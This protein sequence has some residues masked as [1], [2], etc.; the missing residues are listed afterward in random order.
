MIVAKTVDEAVAAIAAGEAML[1]AG[2]TSHA[3]RRERTG[4]PFA[5][6]LVSIMRVP[7]LQVLEIGKD[8]ALTMGAAVRQEQLY[9]NTKLRRDW[10]AIDDALEAVGHARIRQMLTVG[11]SV[12]PL[13]GGFDLPLALLTLGA[14]VTVAGPNGRRTVPLAEAFEKRFAKDEMV[15][16]VAVPPQPMR[17]GSSFFKYMARGVLEIPT[18]N[19]AATVTLDGQGK[20]ERAQVAV[21]A[22]SW[23]PIVLDLAALK[24]KALDDAAVRAAVMPVRAAAQPMSDVRGSAAYKRNMAVEFS[25]RAVLQAAAR[26]AGGKA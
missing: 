2:G 23:K 9:K 20:C 26:A 22:V 3:L 21:G 17:T 11:G 24:G 18:V 4:K 15:V 16:S 1:V 14:S 6:R 13:I 8:G 19:T 10:P 25:V 5:K 7:E 12:G